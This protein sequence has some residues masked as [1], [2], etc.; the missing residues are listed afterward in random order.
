MKHLTN[1]SEQ[2][3]PLRLIEVTEGV[4]SGLQELTRQN[5]PTLYPPELVGTT[6]LPAAMAG[7]TKFEVQE[8]TDFLVRLGVIELPRNET[9]DGTHDG[10]HNDPNA[11]ES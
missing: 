2:I 5:K 1:R 8:A 7:F 9:H 6:M 11:S 10:T 4:I 3:D